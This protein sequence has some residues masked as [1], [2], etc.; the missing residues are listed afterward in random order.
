MWTIRLRTA[1]NHPNIYTMWWAVL[2]AS[3]GFVVSLLL[4][5]T[6]DASCMEHLPTH[7]PPKILKCRQGGKPNFIKHPHIITILMAAMLTIPG[8]KK[9]KKTAAAWMLR[10]RPLSWSQSQRF[11]RSQ[12]G[13]RAVTLVIP[14]SRVTGFAS[15]G[16]SPK[17]WENTRGVLEMAKS[18]WHIFIKM[19]ANRNYLVQ[20]LR[21]QDPDIHHRE[22]RVY[23]PSTT[24]NLTWKPYAQ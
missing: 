12:I 24:N 9:T 10:A 1:A 2:Y 11:Q 6:P 3:P 8:P 17:K 15:G 14:R 18:W 13:L 20:Y 4:Q 23:C 5:P 22:C 21:F 16:S 7:E 19:L